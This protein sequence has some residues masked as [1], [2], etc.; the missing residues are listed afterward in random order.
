MTKILMKVLSGKFMT[1]A[2]IHT[3]VL[4]LTRQQGSSG[5]PPSPSL[6]A[7]VLLCHTVGAV[8][9][10]RGVQATCGHFR[11]SK[12]NKKNKQLT[13]S[14]FSLSLLPLFLSFMQAAYNKSRHV[15]TRHQQLDPVLEPRPQ[16]E[17]QRFRERGS[18]EKTQHD[19]ACF[20][21]LALLSL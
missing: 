5:A 18:P 11:K 21:E 10:S 15:P 2:L 4:A 16:G 8:V 1:S 6:P 12:T 13:T 9:S 3:T 20:S 14:L 7:S 19:S 17:E